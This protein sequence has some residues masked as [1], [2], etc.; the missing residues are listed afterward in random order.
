MLELSFGTNPRRAL[1]VLCIGAHCDDIE[2]G[3]GATLAALRRTRKRLE[4]RWVVLSGGENRRRE[5]TAA[6]RALV[7]PRA[8]NEGIFGG[9]RDGYLP[10]QY[11]AAKELFESLKSLPAPDVIFSHERNDRHQDHRTIC[12]LVWSTFRDHAV[13]EYEIPKWDGGLGT[14]NLYCPVS[15][16]DADAKVQ[17]LMRAYASQAGRDW[18]KPEVFLGLMRLRGMECRAPSGYAEGFYG[19]KL[20]LTP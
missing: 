4:V 1:R 6:M 2:I 16:R 8:F 15:R 17:A 18:F 14:P 20:T 10:A 13:L 12:E 19:H 5:S 3:C 9:L 11:A 7:G